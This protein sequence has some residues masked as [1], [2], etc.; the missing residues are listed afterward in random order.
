MQPIDGEEEG[1]S[2]ARLLATP[3]L[4]G[5]IE[6]KEN[7]KKQKT[8]KDKVDEL[9]NQ[10]YM[11]QSLIGWRYNPFA[12]HLEPFYHPLTMHRTPLTP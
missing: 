6:D 7:Y 10:S 8:K 4:P 9:C 1:R 11:L 12:S 5:G 2:A 3:G